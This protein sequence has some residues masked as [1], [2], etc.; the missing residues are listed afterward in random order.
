VVGHEEHEESPLEQL[1]VEQLL[2]EQLA[3]MFAMVQQ[4]RVTKKIHRF[5]FWFIKNFLL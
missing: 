4:S 2:V 3:T 5:K 1:L